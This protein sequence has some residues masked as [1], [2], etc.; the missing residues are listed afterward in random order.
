[1]GPNGSMLHI[2]YRNIQG[3]VFIYHALLEVTDRNNKKHGTKQGEDQLDKWG[4]K[5]KVSGIISFKFVIK[6]YR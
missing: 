4:L 6:I 2:Q 3:K 5:S 1:M